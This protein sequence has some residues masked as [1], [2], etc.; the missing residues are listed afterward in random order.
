M[1]RRN[2]IAGLAAVGLLP[3][4]GFAD[5]TPRLKVVLNKSNPRESSGLL[6]GEKFAVGFGKHGFKSEGSAFE[7]GYSLLGTFRVNA[8][9]T[10][11]TFAMTDSLVQQSGKSR[12]WLEEK[13]F[14]NMSSIDFDGDGKGGEYGDAFIGL[15]PV[16]TSVQQPFHFGEYKGVFRWYSYAIHGTQDESRIGKC[17]TGGCINVGQKDLLE[18]VEIVKLGDLVEITQPD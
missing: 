8:I 16:D 15:E 14:T 9:L 10:R 1:R 3:K 4:R 11:E 5:T 6:K 7:G 17:I 12:E 13:L 18:L 2:W